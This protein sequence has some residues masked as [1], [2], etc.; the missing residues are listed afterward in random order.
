MEVENKLKSVFT[1]VFG[2]PVS[3]VGVTTKQ[4][5]LEGW[6]SLGQLRLIMAVEEVFDVSFTVA[7]IA[8][9]TDYELV[10]NALL[11]KLDGR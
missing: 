9:L 4:N 6:D 2:I 5:T 7:E 1:D 8:I 10:L 3:K 11:R